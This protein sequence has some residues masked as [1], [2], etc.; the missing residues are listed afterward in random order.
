MRTSLTLVYLGKAVKSST[1]ACS[2]YVLQLAG[3]VGWCGLVVC[4]LYELY[5][6][7]L[8][9]HILYTLLK[10]Q[11]WLQVHLNPMK[12]KQ[13]LYLLICIH[14]PASQAK[15]RNYLDLIIVYLLAPWMAFYMVLQIK[16]LKANSALS[17]CNVPVLSLDLN[18]MRAIFWPLRWHYKPIGSGGI[19]CNSQHGRNW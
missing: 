14:S 2:C 11:C 8:Y 10:P 15:S 18:V 19:Y 3:N 4:G 12:L 17:S 9:L 1:V 5:T 16:L 6:Y 13:F 7:T